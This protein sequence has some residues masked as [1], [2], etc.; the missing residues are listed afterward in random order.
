LA[1]ANALATEL[2]PASIDVILCRQGLQFFPDRLAA[3][4]EMH[5]VLA[6]DGRVLLSVWRS[7]GPYNTAVGDAALQAYAHGDGVAVPDETNIAI[8]Y[9]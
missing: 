8:A 3:L 1:R 5:R 9:A 4:C 2:P 7:A 6:P